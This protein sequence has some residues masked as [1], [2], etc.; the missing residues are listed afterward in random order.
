MLK[1]I[2]YTNILFIYV[3]IYNKILYYYNVFKMFLG[4]YFTQKTKIKI[5]HWS[6]FI[7]Y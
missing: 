6:K 5:K 2:K 1:W 3:C 4:K 7:Y